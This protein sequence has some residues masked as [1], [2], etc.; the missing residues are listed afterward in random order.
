VHGRAHVE[1]EDVEFLFP[2]VIGHRLLFAP[3]FGVVGHKLERLEAVG[4]VWERCLAAAPP[5]SLAL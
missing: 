3:G 4:Q 5:P 1:P 2:S